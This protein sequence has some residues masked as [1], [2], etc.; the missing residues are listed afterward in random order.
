[1]VDQFMGIYVPPVGLSAR[2]IELRA[3]IRI[4]ATFHV[5]AHRLCHIIPC[6]ATNELIFLRGYLGKL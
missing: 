1:M 4:L 5:F 2:L 3:L 6:V